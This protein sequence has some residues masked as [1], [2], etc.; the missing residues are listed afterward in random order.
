MS[1]VKFYYKG[2]RIDIQCTNIS[3]ALFK[4]GKGV[5]KNIKDL[6]FILNAQNLKPLCS[7]Q[8]LESLMINGEF[9]I[10]VEDIQ[11][12][13]EIKSEQIICQNCSSC[14][15]L[16]FKDYKISLQKCKCEIKHTLDNILLEE[17]EETQK[18]KPI[19]INDQFGFNAQNLNPIK[20]EKDDDYYC[21]YCKNCK[22]DLCQVCKS[23]HKDEFKNHNIISLEG[24]FPDKKKLSENYEKLKTVI[25]QFN[26]I[27][28]EFIQKFT[29]VKS[30]LET[31]NNLAHSLFKNFDPLKRSFLIFKNIENFKYDFVIDDLKEIINEKK[32]KKRFNKIFNLYDKMTYIDEI[33]I[34][35]NINEENKKSQELKIF[36]KDFVKK[37]KGKCHILYKDNK[38]ELNEILKIM[39][40]NIKNEDGIDDGNENIY[41]T[42]ML[43]IKLVG[44]NN[45][46]SLSNMFNKCNQLISLPDISKI[47]TINITDISNMFY[48]CINL[49]SLPDFT[50][51]NTCNI[52]NIS[53]LFHGC[54]S[55]KKIPDISKWNTSKVKY[56]SNL[57][58]DCSKITRI[59]DISNWDTSNVT[60]MREMFNGCS[61]L[62]FLPDISKWNRDN[63]NDKFRIFYGCTQLNNVPDI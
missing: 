4:L 9:N 53:G 54:S 13:Q 55:L 39:P 60:T 59:P 35:Y 5:E 50:K 45:L 52:E 7:I 31:L 2:N 28:E 17:F 20:C 29:K 3:D 23:E 57:F 18:I 14:A 36:G 47:N 42:N 22:L 51:W 12:N 27:I 43:R 34:I 19:M 1:K 62:T 25:D 32:V 46:S 58:S 6:K 38:Y 37:N 33:N 49:G 8:E 15:K 26:P 21:A 30:S 41:D 48:E 63:V 61:S 40:D 10:E 44:I 11:K 56:M 24:L 16:V